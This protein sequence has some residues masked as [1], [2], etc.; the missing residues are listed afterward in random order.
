[1]HHFVKKGGLFSS[2]RKEER[3][4]VREL[5][6]K[7]LGEASASFLSHQ[8][9]LCSDPL[10]AEKWYLTISMVFEAKEK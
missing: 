2:K 1:M 3:A 5:A 4:S 6:I 9:Q 10:H 8:P 7:E